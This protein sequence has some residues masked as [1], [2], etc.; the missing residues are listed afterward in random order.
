[1]SNTKGIE[2]ILLIIACILF[3]PLIFLIGLG[4]LTG[5]L[6]LNI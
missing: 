4:L 1:M 5:A 6:E 3:P 2:T